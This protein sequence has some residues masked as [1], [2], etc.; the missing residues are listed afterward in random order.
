MLADDFSRTIALDPFR[1]GV[2]ARNLAV[3]RQ[4]IDGI[5][6]NA[7]HQ[8]PELFLT[9][10]KR[11]FGKPS[12]GKI[13]RDLGE[14][15]QVAGGILDGIDDDIGPEPGA[16]LS[17]APALPFEFSFARG[18]L[19]RSSGQALFAI[20]L[21]VKA[22]EVL[23]KD[24]GFFVP[25]ETPRAGVP[26]RYVSIRIEH[27]DGVIVDGFD[28]HPIAAIVRRRCIGPLSLLHEYYPGLSTTS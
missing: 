21:G 18:D 11:L 24:F 28:Q 14:T 16:V 8:E 25:F 20:G 1:T 10:P 4:H 23:A 2:P 19:E 17:A 9:F 15:N 7:L 22:R 26:A 13:A 27:V 12:L 6:R 3:R 5:V